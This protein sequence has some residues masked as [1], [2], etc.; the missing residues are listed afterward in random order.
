MVKNNFTSCLCKFYISVVEKKK[1]SV[2]FCTKRYYNCWK[3]IFIW[4]K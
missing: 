3:E 4:V 1:Q 2:I